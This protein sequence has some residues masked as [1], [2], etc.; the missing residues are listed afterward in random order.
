MAATSSISMPP[1]AEAMKT[2]LPLRA[3]EHDAEV[4]FALDGQRLF[5]Q[6][7]LHD[8]AFGAGLVRDQRHA[9]DLVGDARR[10]RAA[11]LATLTPPP[12]P[13]PPAWICALTT[14]LPPMFLRGRL[15]FFHRERH[16][17]ARHRDIVFGQD[18]LG[19]ILVNFHGDARAV[20]VWPDKAQR[21][22]NY[23]MSFLPVPAPQSPSARESVRGRSR[24]RPCRA[25]LAGEATPAQIAGVSDG[26]ADERRDGGRAGGLRAGHAADGGARRFARLDGEPLL[27]T[28]GTG[29]DGAGTFNISTVAAFVVAGAGVRVAK[30]GNRSISSQCGSADLLEALGVAILRRP[31]R[32]ARAIREVGIGFLFAPAMH[33]AMKHAQ[34]VRLESEDAHGVQPAGAADESRR[35]RRRRW[36][37]RPRSRR[38]N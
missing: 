27:D 28:C 6:Q 30:H 33:T 16:L 26:A 8:A 36:W 4:E 31:E 38:R 32:C 14:T 12:L 24:R 5:D 15:G 20:L 25:I 9:E 3:V 7:A 11:S 17:A 1:A 23:S 19:L 2:G 37:A 34:P 13:R 29:G 10:L 18:G 21:I 35:A 22:P